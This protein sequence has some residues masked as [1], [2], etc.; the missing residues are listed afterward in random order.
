MREERKP[1]NMNWLDAVYFKVDKGAVRDR[2][3]LAKELR[4][5][6]KK[7]EKASG[8]ETDMRSIE[9]ALEDFSVLFLYYI[10]M[11]LLQI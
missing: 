3:N 6:L 2:Y 5:K 7:E 9:V 4:T 10:L 8:I 1:E 11:S